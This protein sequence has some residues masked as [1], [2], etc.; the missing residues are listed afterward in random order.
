MAFLSE[1]Q[2]SVEGRGKELRPEGNGG[3]ENRKF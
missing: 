3:T 2:L 1:V